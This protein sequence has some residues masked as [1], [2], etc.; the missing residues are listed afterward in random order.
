[1]RVFWLRRSRW[2]FA[3]GPMLTFVMNSGCPISV[4]ER[5]YGADVWNDP[6][7]TWRASLKLA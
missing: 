4:A 5:T 6:F 7:R 2:M 3:N 1:M